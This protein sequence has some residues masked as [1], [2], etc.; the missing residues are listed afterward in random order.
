MSRRNRR[1]MAM[2][3][4]FS[5]GRRSASCAFRRGS[6][7]RRYCQLDM[8][9]SWVSIRRTGTGVS[10]SRHPG[11]H[12]Q[13]SREQP[14]K[15]PRRFGLIF[16]CRQLLNLWVKGGGSSLDA[17]WTISPVSKVSRIAS[18]DGSQVRFGRDVDRVRFEPRSMADDPFANA[19]PTIR[20]FASSLQRLR[21]RLRRPISTTSRRRTPWNTSLFAPSMRAKMM[22]SRQTDNAAAT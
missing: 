1:S 9:R 11:C 20:S 7:W 15:T 3:R 12:S 18:C 10:R 13:T 19:S 4:G 16:G 8:R 5:A 14:R 17:P 6:G 21:L 2:H 22:K